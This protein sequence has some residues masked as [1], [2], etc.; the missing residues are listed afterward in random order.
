M[1]VFTAGPALTQWNANAALK[2]G[3]AHIAT[4]ADQVD[5]AQLDHF[6]SVALAV[7]LAWTRATRA[8]GMTLRILNPPTQLT[9]LARAYGIDTLILD[10]KNNT[11]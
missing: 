5:C 4:G 2:T 3:L 7:L 9:N 8:R 10:C 11:L 1:T 6:D